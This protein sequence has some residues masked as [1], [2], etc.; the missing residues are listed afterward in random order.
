MYMV[1]DSNLQKIPLSFA[2]FEF[3]NMTLSDA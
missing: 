3:A 2:P 1:H